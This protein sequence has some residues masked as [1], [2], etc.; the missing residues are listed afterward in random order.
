MAKLP[1][2]AK[3]RIGLLQSSSSL[4][5]QLLLVLLLELDLCFCG[6]CG[7]GADDG[8]LVI[9]DDLKKP[10]LPVMPVL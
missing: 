10:P 9:D 4:W 3:H 7:V 8:W 5:L 2:V 6:G 1:G